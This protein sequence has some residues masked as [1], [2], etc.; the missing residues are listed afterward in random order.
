[1]VPFI[2]SSVDVSWDD[3]FYVVLQALKLLRAIDSLRKLPLQAID[4]EQ[5]TVEQLISSN[6]SRS[7]HIPLSILKGS[8]I[9]VNKKKD[10]GYNS[11]IAMTGSQTTLVS[12]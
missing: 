12:V 3:T 9:S 5:F 2:S 7:I 6:L 1:M 4:F 11:Q 10:D 8:L